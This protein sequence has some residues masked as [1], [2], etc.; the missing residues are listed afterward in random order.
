[1][2]QL[3]MREPTFLILASLAAGRKHGYSIIQETATLSEGRVNLK[4]GTLYAALDRLEQQGLVVR[5]GDEAV[6]GR[7]RRYFE[8]SDDGARALEHEISRLEQN[9]AV[10]KANLG[11]RPAA[12]MAVW[13]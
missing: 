12:T 5:A 3:D 4:V 13:A 1:M 11:L 7:L 2:T 8:L 9:V 6:D 10:A